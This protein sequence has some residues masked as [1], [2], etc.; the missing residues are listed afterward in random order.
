M[1]IL[2]LL[3][4]LLNIMMI[5]IMN[6]IIIQTMIIMIMIIQGPV[7]AFFANAGIGLDFGGAASIDMEQW[8]LMMAVTREFKDTIDSSVESDTLFLE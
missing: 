4:L 7:D 3:L 8:R 1:L 2:M 5:M 6:I